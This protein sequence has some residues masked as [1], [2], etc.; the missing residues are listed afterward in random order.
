M[1]LRGWGSSG[2][3]LAGLTVGVLA[4]CGTAAAPTGIS[5]PAKQAITMSNSPR[6]GGLAGQHARAYALRLLAK[7]DLPADARR[8][9]WPARQSRLLKPLLPVWLGDVV[10]AR[11]LYRVG[12][13]TGLDQFLAGHVPTGMLPGESGQG[14]TGGGVFVDYIPA[15]LPAGIASAYLAAVI[16]PSGRSALVRADAQVVWYPPRS[17]TEYIHPG[18]YRSVTVTAL[19][20][21]RAFTAPS[22]ITGL[23]ALLNRMPALPPEVRM[24]PAITGTYRVVF[25]PRAA[26]W[27]QVVVTPSGCGS[28]GIRVGGRGQPTLDEHGDRVISALLQLLGPPAPK[29]K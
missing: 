21:T 28:D 14:G 12:S 19:A 6:A 17:A 26:R 8:T 4:A 23:A 13:S 3:T 16:I 1:F 27:P 25:T 7:L 5:A 29:P 15:H 9:A 11:A 24:C 2:L 22:V 18:R 20:V 10:D